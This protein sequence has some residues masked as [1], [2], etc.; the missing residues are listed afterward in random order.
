MFSQGIAAFD[1][2]KYTRDVEKVN[3]QNIQN[4]GVSE[5]DRVRYAAR[6]QMGQQ[7]VDQGGSGFSTGT[8]TALDALHASAINRELDFA[9]SRA[10]ANGQMAEH[11]QKGRMAYN[12]GKSAMVGGIIS[13]AAEI[14]QEVAGGFAGAAG[15]GAAGGGGLGDLSSFTP[16]LDPSALSGGWGN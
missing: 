6:L 16:G 12:Q 8:G 1:A 15:A 2:G 7:L 10:K 5:R 13:G 3:A 14:A 4:M 11:L 9:M